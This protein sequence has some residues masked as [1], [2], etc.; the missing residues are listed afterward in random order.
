M[1]TKIIYQ[2]DIVKGCCF[3]N[4]NIILIWYWFFSY[5]LIF[6]LEDGNNII[7]IVLLYIACKNKYSEYVI[8]I[9]M[10]YQYFHCFFVI[11]MGKL[12]L[13]NVYTFRKSPYVI[14][15]GSPYSLPWGPHIYFIFIWSNVVG[16][17]TTSF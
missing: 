13:F 1:A 4:G 16:L 5:K 8:L 6:N 7:I 12:Y 9:N 15:V 10:G 14:N 11:N 3:C 2:K 17:A